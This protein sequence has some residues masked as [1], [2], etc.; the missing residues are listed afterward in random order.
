MINKVLVIGPHTDD[1]EFGCG[2]TISRYSEEGKEIFYATFSNA[3]ESIPEGLPK[4]IT[5]NEVK[6][7]CEVL[8][9]PKNNIFNF[10][11]PVRKFPHFRQEILEE[12]VKMNRDLDPDL[13]L[14]PSSH[15]VHQDHNTIYNECV[16]A[17]KFK[18]MLGYEMPWN[19]LQFSNTAFIDLEKH[20]VEKK[21]EA[22][23]CFESQKGKRYTNKE[24]IL[25][26]AMTRGVQVR[27]NYAEAFE[28][29]RWIM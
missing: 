11:F 23:M 1:C 24:Y 14:S 10:N 6:K 9:I 7:S 8:D 17:F 28:I 25:G 22:I 3:E 16:R 19:N 20:H 29:I 4:D 2:G 12:L 15:D 18:S 27:K 5:R 26:L 13:I 21:A